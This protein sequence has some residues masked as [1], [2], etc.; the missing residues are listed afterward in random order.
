[1]MNSRFFTISAMIFIAAISRILPHPPNFSPILGVSLFAGAVLSRKSEALLVPVAAM[2]IS[3]LV[4]G[5]HSLMYIVYPCI[6]LMV[7]MG[8]F[9]KEKLSALKILGASL[10]GSIV[11]FVVTNFF[12]FLTSGMY[13]Q[14][15]SG[16]VQAYTLAIPFFQNSVLGDLFFSSI[17]FGTLHILESKGW[18][19]QKEGA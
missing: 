2:L 19:L 16:L 11:F 3:D 13:S 4:I 10:T 7:F 1:M 17:L 5:F 8:S 6:I 12:V 9:I 15:F 18:I 14:N